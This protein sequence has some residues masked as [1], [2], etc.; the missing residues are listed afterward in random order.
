M[1]ERGDLDLRFDLTDSSL[2]ECIFGDLD[3]GDFVSLFDSSSLVPSIA[4]VA[5]LELESE[6][7]GH[8][9]GVLAICIWCIGLCSP[10]RIWFELLLGACPSWVLGT[11]DGL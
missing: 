9:C 3:L 4:L 6:G 1:E 7:F 8:L 11:L 2:C 5:F 10:R